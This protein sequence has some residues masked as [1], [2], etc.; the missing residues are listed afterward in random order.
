[1]ETDLTVMLAD[2]YRADTQTQAYPKY[3]PQIKRIDLYEFIEDDVMVFV[4]NAATPV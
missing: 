1:M 2:N 3:L 4:W